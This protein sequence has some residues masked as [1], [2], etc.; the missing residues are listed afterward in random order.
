MRKSSRATRNGKKS[1]ESE[2]A[3]EDL[4]GNCTEV[5][6]GKC[7]T[8]M[9]DREEGNGECR[10]G[11]RE[12]SDS[13]FAGKRIETNRASLRGERGRSRAERGKS[14]GEARI[15]EHGSRVSNP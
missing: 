12:G 15:W 2:H 10:A 11:K 8:F 9:T 14:G 5:G 13:F 3:P 4:M 7:S 6:R 1:E